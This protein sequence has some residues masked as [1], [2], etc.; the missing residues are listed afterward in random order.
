MRNISRISAALA[1]SIG[2][3]S[4]TSLGGGRSVT[5]PL[6]CSH[7]PSRQAFRALVTLPDSQPT[8]SRF[9]VRIDS[10]PS[11]KVSHMGLNYIFDMSTDYQVPAGTKYVEGSLR[12]VPDTGSANARSARAW[13][14]TT[15]IHLLIPA[16]VEN[17]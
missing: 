17:G 7:G 2:L 12:I 10:F 6:V 5:V 8:G 16:R 9:T 11:G 4:T 3:T 15:G 13:R 14:D 1:L